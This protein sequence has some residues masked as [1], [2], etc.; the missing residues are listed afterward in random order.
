[1]IFPVASRGH[2]QPE[3]KILART[4]GSLSSEQ[5]WGKGGWRR[6]REMWG[7]GRGGR[8]GNR[9]QVAKIK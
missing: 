6:S 5:K 3:H 8:R 1:M 7:T 4:Q 9:S 2:Q